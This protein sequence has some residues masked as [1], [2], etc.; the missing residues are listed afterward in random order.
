MN[1][2]TSY[3]WVLHTAIDTTD[4]RGL[5]EFYRE[6]LGLRCRSGYEPPWKRWSRASTK[7][8]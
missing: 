6:F 4:V 7:W 5:A 1:G 3:P 8:V 2:G